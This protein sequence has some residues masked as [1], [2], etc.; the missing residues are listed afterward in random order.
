MACGSKGAKQNNATSTEPQSQTEQ[1]AAIPDHVEVLYF[2][3]KKRCVTCM[4]IE[5][6]TQEVV[7]TEFANQ[8]ADNSVVYRSIDISEAENE[9]IADH[10]EVTWSS[11]FVVQWH[12]GKEIYDNLTE[13]AFA[14]ARNN[15]DEFKD[16]LTDKINQLLQ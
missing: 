12:D 7:E 11:L 15:T 14:N 2:H 16:N 9:A 1:V 8:L 10:Y 13:Y 5:K 6:Y 3:S 4:A